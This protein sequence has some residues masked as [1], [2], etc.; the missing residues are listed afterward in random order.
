MLGFHHG[1]KMRMANLQKLFAAEPRFR[2]MW[3]KAKHCYIHCGHLHH[4]RVLDDAGATIEQH[5]TLSA[6]DHYSS[7]H[8]Y[9]SQ[10]G[11]KVI[12]YDKL[13]GEIHR[14]TVR[15]RYDKDS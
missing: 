15:P 11:A 1:H 13:D 4:E 12:T 2:E 6:R 14:V 7:S 5:P 3:G 8:G 10:R 9:I